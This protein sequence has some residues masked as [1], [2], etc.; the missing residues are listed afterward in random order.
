MQARLK[1]IGWFSGD[2]SDNYGSR[3]TE[4]VQGFQRKRGFP[5]TGV[6]DERTYN[7]ILSMTRTPTRD[8]LDNVKPAAPKP[9]AAT[10]TST[11]GA[12]PAE[13]SASASRRGHRTWSSTARQYSMAV[14]FGSEAEPTREGVFG[15][16]WKKV[17]V[18]SN[19]Y[20]TPMP[21]SMFFSGGQAIHYSGDFAASGQ[22]L[23]ARLRQRSQ[24]DPAQAALQRRAG[25]HEGRRPL[26]TTGGPLA[27]ASSRR[28]APGAPGLVVGY[29]PP[30]GPPVGPGCHNEEVQML[31]VGWKAS[32]EQFGPR[33]LVDF[34]VRAEQDGLDSVF[35]SDHFQPWRHNDGHAPFAMSWLAAAGERTER[36]TLGTSVMAPT[37]RYNPAVVARPSGRGC[38]QSRADRARHRDGRGAQRG[39]RGR[40]RLAWPE[41]KERF[42][43]S[44]EAV[45]LIRRL[46]TEERVSFEGDYYTT[47]DATV[48]DRPEQHRCRSTS[49]PADRWS[50][51]TPVGP[52]TGSSAPPARG[53][54]STRTSCSPPSTMG[55]ASPDAPATT[56]TS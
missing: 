3:T 39:R 47:R 15:I 40:R 33:E 54:S 52:A 4:A 22:R 6:T 25:R 9:S 29:S 30:G 14:R 48:Y 34:T 23:V 11:R 19:L 5:V 10:G 50:P 53:V 45:T 18:I 31:K 16:T 41:F 21:Y 26:V 28:P 2:V 42:A 38:P 13:S 46:W 27:A 1:Q 17:D 37:F 36:I 35:I 7:R 12:S 55:W 24:H 20:D 8:E 49:P 43:G 44:R 51:A 56:S 32:A